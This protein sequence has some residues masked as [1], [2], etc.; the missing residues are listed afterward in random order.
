MARSG[1]RGIRRLIIVVVVLLALLA[2]ADRIALAVAEHIAASNIQSSQ[3]L[4]HRPDVEVAGFPFLNQLAEGSFDE[5]TMTAHD[6]CIGPSNGLVDLSTLRVVLHQVDASRDFSTVHA[7][8][9]TATAKIGYDELSDALH[10]NVS[11]AGKGRVRTSKSVTIAG[12]K[13]TAGITSTPTIANDVLSFTSTSINGTADLGETVTDELKKVFDLD[14]PFQGI[15]F[16]VRVQNLSLDR[17]GLDLRLAGS[18][19]TYTK[20]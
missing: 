20:T 9:A 10:L 2:A 12:K 19:L 15:P 6:V 1:S 18:D 14:L 13:L 16:D 8:S 4:Q 11:Y 3:D 5:V 17:D 7:K